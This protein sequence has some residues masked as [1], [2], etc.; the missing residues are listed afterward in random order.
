MEF[1]VLPEI[2][3]R[4][5]TLDE[6]VARLSAS[7]VVDGLALFG[8]RPAGNITPLSDIDLLVLVRHQPARIFQLF[9][10]IANRLADVVLVETALADQILA[11]TA[12]VAAG[13]FE[14]MFLCKMVHAELVYDPSGRLQQVQQWV[15]T[16]PQ[17]A[18]LQPAGYAAGYGAWFWQNHALAHLQRIVESD[19][20]A[21][22]TEFDLMLGACL[23]DLGR[24]YC[25]L[26]GLPWEGYKT[27]VR[28]WM[29]HDPA[30]LERL[31]TCLA[32]PDR[33]QKVAL[34]RTLVTQVLAPVGG[35]WPPGGTAV[36]L[37][38]SSQH[39]TQAAVALAYWEELLAG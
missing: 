6:T 20:P 22:Q 15:T 35:S 36:W 25:T 5:L 32:A 4:H 23:A 37:I 11:E 39:E 13:S 33:A 34:Y 17:A 14:S 38:D 12:P 8:S 18:W 3:A 21:H 1:P 7:P 31:R 19:D 16:Q 24:A 30:L 2:A 29:A 9:T 10:C 26:R 27:A 28:T